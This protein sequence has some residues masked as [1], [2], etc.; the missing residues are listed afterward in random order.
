MLTAVIALISFAVAFVGGCVMTKAYF[1]TKGAP[2]LVHR[3][4]VHALLQ[5]QRVR[6]RKRL[7]ALN[8]VIRRHE[9]TRDQI[10]EKL[11]NIENKHAE[12]GESLHRV[13]AKLHQEQEQTQNLQQQLTKLEHCSTN[14]QADETSTSALENELGMLRIEKDDLAAR[15]RRSEEEQAQIVATAESSETVDEIARM[16]ADMGELRETL[17][18]RNRRVHDLELQLQESAKQARE[19]QA[20]LDNWKQRV[21]PLTRK[22]M[23]QKKVIQSFCLDNDTEHQGDD[24]KAIRGIGPAL[25]RRLQQQGIQ[26]YR[27]LAEMTSD[28][29][30]DIAKKLD[31]APN[32]V[33]RDAWSEQAQDLMEKAELSE[34]V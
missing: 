18:T 17:A 15:V 33:E 23:Q 21:T 13:K 20:K 3:N 34:T 26:H 28:E 22:L 14:V 32:L 10:R 16:R 2:D 4:K 30:A 5:A 25:E 7:V 19:L 24:L 27:Q 1:L 11:T 12:R 8:N 6:Y 29:L 31:I 9:D